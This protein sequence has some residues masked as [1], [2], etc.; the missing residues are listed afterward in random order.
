MQ[1]EYGKERDPKD[2]WN[3][4]MPQDSELALMKHLRE[5]YFHAL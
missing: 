2:E 3:N 1:Y 5:H 4:P